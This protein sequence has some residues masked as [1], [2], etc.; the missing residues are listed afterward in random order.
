MKSSRCA[1]RIP[2]S[3]STR[4]IE[5]T[6]RPER[7]YQALSLIYTTKMDALNFPLCTD[8]SNYAIYTDLPLIWHITLVTD[9]V[10]TLL[11]SSPKRSSH[12]NRHQPSKKRKLHNAWKTMYDLAEST[13]CGLQG[14]VAPGTCLH[15]LWILRKESELNTISLHD[16][17]ASMLIPYIG[18]P[19]DT[20]RFLFLKPSANSVK[21]GLTRLWMTGVLMSWVKLLQRNWINVEIQPNHSSGTQKRRERKGSRTRT[22]KVRDHPRL[23]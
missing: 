22:S 10:E 12:G 20:T 14:W 21:M 13:I 15:C 6:I 18:T 16:K 9:G 8:D 4:S 5:I 7:E 2:R 11:F 17:F 23:T 19:T 1:S 3:S